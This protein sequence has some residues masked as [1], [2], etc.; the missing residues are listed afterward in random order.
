[1]ETPA[2]EPAEPTALL[3]DFGGVLT[4]NVFESFA[5]FSAAE[6]GDPDAV[7]VLFAQ[8]EQAQKLLVEHECGRISEPEFSAGFAALL[9]ARFGANVV[10]EGMAGRMLAGTQRDERML[11]AVARVK[12]AGVPTAIVSNSMGDRG[13]QGF[14]MQSLADV[15]VISGEHGVRKPSRRLYLIACEQLGVDPTNCV[16]VDDVPRNLSGAARLG[17]RGV[18]HTK[19]DD[20]IAELEALFGLDLAP[21]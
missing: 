9:N 6:C 17:I 15:V 4:T 14:D 20:T 21:A 12:A 19:A 8:D 10:A 7:R 1:M 16:M 3:V 13:Y 11:A 18:H 2:P 5:A